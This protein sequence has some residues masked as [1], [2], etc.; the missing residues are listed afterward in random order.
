MS[1]ASWVEQHKRPCILCYPNVFWITMDFARRRNK[2][3]KHLNYWTEEPFSSSQ[4][5]S[6]HFCVLRYQRLQIH[7][8][9]TIHYWH[10]KGT[11]KH[12]IEFMESSLPQLQNK[13][14]G[15]IYISHC[16]QHSLNRTHTTTSH[17]DGRVANLDAFWWTYQLWHWW[18]NVCVRILIYAPIYN[19]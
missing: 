17:L 18:I 11:S 14:S 4:L 12:M 7:N 9:L 6:L 10:T 15:N 8:G 2:K 3:Q 19:L 5:I 1:L 16:V 13:Q